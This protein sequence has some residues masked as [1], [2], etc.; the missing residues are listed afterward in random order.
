MKQRQ[1]GTWLPWTCANVWEVLTNLQALAFC[2]RLQ[3][4]IRWHMQQ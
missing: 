4:Q 2:V 3:S 1:K